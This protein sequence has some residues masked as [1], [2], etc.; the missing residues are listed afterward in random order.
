MMRSLLWL[1]NRK[2][3]LLTPDINSPVCNGGGGP[4]VFAQFISGDD[5]EFVT[6]LDDRRDAIIGRK[7]D[8]TVGRQQ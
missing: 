7:V 3:V 5:V 1:S 2:Q 6:W 8:Q 4:C